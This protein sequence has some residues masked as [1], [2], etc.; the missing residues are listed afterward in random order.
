M[1]KLLYRFVSNTWM[2]AIG[3]LAGSLA[4]LDGCF[5]L[6]GPLAFSLAGVMIALSI[7]LI[8]EAHAEDRRPPTGVLILLAIL[9]MASHP[10]AAPLLLALYFST[11]MVAPLQRRPAAAVA[12]VIA[13]YAFLISRDSPEPVPRAVLMQMADFS[14]GHTWSNLKDLATWDVWYI[15]RLFGESLRVLNGYVYFVAA[16]KTVGALAAVLLFRRFRKNRALRLLLA[17]EVAF[18]G[19]YLIFAEK[20]VPEWPYR[21]LSVTHPVTFSFGVIAL[22]EACALIRWPESLRRFAAAAW[23]PSMGYA[24][25]AAIGIYLSAAQVQLMARGRVLESA[26]RNLKFTVM[27]S[28]ARDAVLTIEGLDNVQPHYLRAAHSSCSPIPTSSPA[29]SCCLPSG[30]CS[31]DTTA[32]FPRWTSRRCAPVWCSD[33]SRRDSPSRP[34]CFR[35]A[36]R[37]HRRGCILSALSWSRA[38]TVPRPDSDVAPDGRR[39][40]SVHIVSP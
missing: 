29:I 16:V 34:R 6:G 20:V 13:G 19:M 8:L 23:R 25:L 32:G 17:L 18:L 7:L 4:L 39:S 31:R 10:F 3:I 36:G 11:Y 2:R 15:D 14:F 40:V 21:I 1:V 37:L 35:R 9:A 38:A 12:A 33:S 24:A 26:Y 28:G 27:N 5:L 30:T 22:A